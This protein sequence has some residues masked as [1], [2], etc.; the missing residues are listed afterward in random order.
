MTKPKDVDNSGN[1]TFKNH[2]RDVIVLIVISCLSM[3]IAN[4]TVLNFTV[5][6]MKQDLKEVY[7]LNL[8]EL[9][10]QKLTPMYTDKESSWLF[11]AV[12]MGAILGTW[13]MATLNFKYGA[14]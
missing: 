6:C 13:P 5:I 3:V 1:F 8:T 11:S 7:L 10:V 4:S 9:M 14:R 12:A 2:T